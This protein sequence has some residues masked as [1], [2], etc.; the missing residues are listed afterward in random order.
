MITACRVVASDEIG[1]GTLSFQVG[2]ASNYGVLLVGFDFHPT[3]ERDD[4]RKLEES[5]S[6]DAPGDVTSMSIGA[7]CLISGVSAAAYWTSRAAAMAVLLPN[8]GVQTE[9]VHGTA[10][11]TFSGQA[12]V[13]API[14][15][16]GMSPPLTV[17]M[18][19]ATAFHVDWVN[20][21]GYW[22]AVSGD[23]VVKL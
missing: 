5:G 9:N 17:E 3:V 12:E 14:S 13:Y 1:G 2:A 7:D 6:W 16:A 10:Y 19:Y 23:A 8:Q 11:V 18:P 15:L 22:R 20:D 21:Y 4:S